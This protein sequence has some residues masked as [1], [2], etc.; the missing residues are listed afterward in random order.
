MAAVR[1]KA[2]KLTRIR[3]GYQSRKAVRHDPGGSHALLQLRDFDDER[4]EIAVERMAR[5]VPGSIAK[6]QVLRDGDVVFLAKGARNFAFV[7]TGLPEPALVASYFFILRPCE[8]IEAGYLAWYLNLEST[9]RLLSRYVGQGT[10]MPVVRREV[11]ENLAVPVPPMTTQRGIIAL[12]KLADEQ[13]RLLGELAEKRRL[14]ATGV[15]MRAAEDATGEQ[16]DR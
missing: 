9:R 11:L 1:I 4:R 14:L 16:G 12:A 15:C 10:H 2:G 13:G 5:I 8:R 7:P 3:A 6:E